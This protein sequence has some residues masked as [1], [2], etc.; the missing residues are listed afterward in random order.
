MVRRE[1]ELT[2]ILE[3]LREAW[4]QL[5]DSGQSRKIDKAYLLD[6]LNDPR[7]VANS[8][9]QI[10]KIIENITKSGNLDSKL[11]KAYSSMFVGKIPPYMNQV[12]GL[13]DLLQH[14]MIAAI[15]GKFEKYPG[16]KVCDEAS[17]IGKILG[18]D[19]K[20]LE[21]YR[22]TLIWLTYKLG[23]FKL[24][25]VPMIIDMEKFKES[26]EECKRGDPIVEYT[27]KADRKSGFEM[28]YNT[29]IKICA[30]LKLLK[31]KIPPN[32]GLYISTA[33]GDSNERKELIVLGSLGTTSPSRGVVQ[34]FPYK[35]KPY[36]AIVRPNE[37]TGMSITVN[38]EKYL[39]NIYISSDILSK[40]SLE[41]IV[42]EAIVNTLLLN[43]RDNNIGISY[44]IY[45]N[46][47]G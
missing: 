18:I 41:D 38:S 19:P 12:P 31:S 33:R 35:G 6:L 39:Q 44:Q 4:E 3:A 46:G 45:R 11:S 2:I 10:E 30:I 21:D 34:I 28:D 42:R 37:T 1:I 9:S 15:P 40:G 26:L 14:T 29:Y 47:L 16:V 17:E 36:A 22:N 23:L 24:D 8:K 7:I 5:T 25:I 43:K 20:R 27:R 13:E 32:E